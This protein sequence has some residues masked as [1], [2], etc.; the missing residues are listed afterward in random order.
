[1]NILVY[2]DHVQDGERWYKNGMHLCKVVE[3]W[4]FSVCEQ[5]SLHSGENQGLV[6]NSSD[7]SI[8][9]LNVKQ[10]RCLNIIRPCCATIFEHQLDLEPPFSD[11]IVTIFRKVAGRKQQRLSLLNQI[12]RPND[13]VVDVQQPHRYGSHRPHDTLRIHGIVS[14]ITLIVKTDRSLDT[15]KV[16]NRD[17]NAGHNILH[18][19]CTMYTLMNVIRS[20]KC[21][22]TLFMI[23]EQDFNPPPQHLKPLSKSFNK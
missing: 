2:A 21:I 6:P 19:V 10:L 20:F 22:H 1:M 17:I 7:T 4:H 3:C 12:N 8:D 9:G 18:K 15:I 13:G 16:W 23:L 14:K 5:Y 11:E